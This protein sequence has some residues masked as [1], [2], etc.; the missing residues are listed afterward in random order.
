MAFLD[1]YIYLA[2]RLPDADL[3]HMSCFFCPDFESSVT[4]MATKCMVDHSFKALPASAIAAG[5]IYF[6]RE[7]AMVEPVWT[8]ALSRLTGH[9]APT[10]RSVQR[11]LELLDAIAHDEAVTAQGLNDDSQLLIDS[12]EENSM[13]D[14]REETDALAAVMQGMGVEEQL[15]SYQH[16]SHSPSPEGDEENARPAQSGLSSAAARVMGMFS[17]QKKP[18][19]PQLLVTPALKAQGGAAGEKTDL[20]PVSIADYGL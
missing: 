12:S 7:T 10:S 15:A 11:V 8:S 6:T 16:R 9:D 5:I 18:L 2:Q 1:S 3:E 14:S 19:Q 13:E 17:A 20:S 4:R